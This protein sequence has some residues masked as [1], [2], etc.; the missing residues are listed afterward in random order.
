MR[1]SDYDSDARE[2]TLTAHDN[3]F[4]V[5]KGRQWRMKKYK[6]D[7]HI[8]SPFVLGVLEKECGE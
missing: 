6:L 5:V 8:W 2:S 7:R 3:G 1:E 4:R